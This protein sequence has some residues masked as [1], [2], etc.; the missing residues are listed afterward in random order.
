MNLPAK[1]G[2]WSVKHPILGVLVFVV[3]SLLLGGSGW[4][5]PYINPQKIN[6]NPTISCPQ[7]QKMG[8]KDTDQGGGPICKTKNF[9][10]NEWENRD[11]LDNKDGYLCP[12][13]GWV[14]PVLWYKEGVKPGFS[15]IYIEFEIKKDL[16]NITPNPPSFITAYGKDLPIFKSWS[17]EEPNLQLFRFAKNLDLNRK[18][19]TGE[20]GEEFS[21]PVKPYQKDSFTIEQNRVLETGEVLLNFTYK[22]SSNLTGEAESPETFPKKVR[23]PGSDPGLSSVR[24]PFGIGTFEGNCLKPLIIKICE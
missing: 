6:C 1:Y 13:N 14:D 22:Y 17:P 8:D 20:L 9:D 12:K 11:Y 5:M 19:L 16:K 3:Y 4:V 24:Y 21:N 18:I 7:P 23:M 10:P 2:K 15:S